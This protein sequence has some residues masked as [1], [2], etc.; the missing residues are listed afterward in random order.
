ML[1]SEKGNPRVCLYER[2]GRFIEMLLNARMLGS[3]HE[4]YEI[5]TSENRLFVAYRKE[6]KV[7]KRNPPNRFASLGGGESE[8][9]G[10][11]G[12]K[13]IQECIPAILLILC[14]LN[15]LFPTCHILR[16]SKQ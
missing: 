12:G 6:I 5:Q 7:F 8:A 14:L 16:A 3:G 13:T 1:T 9:I 4:A 11:R 2:S 15:L 10:G